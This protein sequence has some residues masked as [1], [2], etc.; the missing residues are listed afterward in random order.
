MNVRHS[1]HLEHAE[2]PV[3][4]TR[5]STVDSV[6]GDLA[7]GAPLSVKEACSPPSGPGGVYSQILGAAVA[8]AGSPF[9]LLKTFEYEQT[10]RVHAAPIS[11]VLRRRPATS[12]HLDNVPADLDLNCLDRAVE[13]LTRSESAMPTRVLVPRLAGAWSPPA[14]AHELAPHLVWL[15]PLYAG[16][17][18]LGVLG[19]SPSGRT[20]D[21]RWGH[22]L[23]V[24]VQSAA[25]VLQ[26]RDLEQRCARLENELR[27]REQRWD[28]A[29]E[30]SAGGT[31]DWDICRNELHLSPRWKAMFGTA[32]EDTPESL[33]AWRQLVHPEDLPRL[34]QAME[35]HLSGARIAFECEYR[36]RHHDASWRW[37]AGRGRVITW[38]DHG[39]PTRFV[40]T[41]TDITDH[42]ADEQA[43]LT[44]REAAVAAARGKSDLLTV[45]SH[46][47]RAPLNAVHGMATLLAGTPLDRQQH[48][49]VTAIRSDSSD[50]LSALDN[51][52]DLSTLQ[53]GELNV[54]PSPF[55][56]RALAT[57]VLYLVKAQAAAKD[58]SLR[59]NGPLHPVW[60]LGNARAVRQ[61]L[62]HL[63]DNA[64]KFTESG[65]ITVSFSHLNDEV[66]RLWFRIEDTGVGIPEDQLVTIFEPFVKVNHHQGSSRGTGLGL[67]IC[68]H[69]VQSLHGEIGV[70][71]REGRGSTFEVTMP[72]PL[73]AEPAL[74]SDGPADWS[75]VIEHKLRERAPCILVAEDNPVNQKVARAFLERL[76]ARVD[77][78]ENGLQAVQA[79]TRFP[80]DLVLMDCQMP[81]MDGFEATEQ[82]RRMEGNSGH[83]PVV[84]L[85]ANALERAR[86]RSVAVGMNAFLTKPLQGH[87][88]RLTLHDSLFGQTSSEKPKV[89]S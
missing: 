7:P 38:D 35:A 56:P 1:V 68:R 52:L 9:A 63:V 40:G 39:N 53:S 70:Q 42:K 43:L 84:A 15:F 76:G 44:A 51:V 60:T 16:G 62:L 21:H 74:P 80:Y 32:P 47:L 18:L 66:P 61:V 78:V 24:L 49:Y 31:F 33:S 46:E 82:I 83:T 4:D 30:A 64:V 5:A 79:L 3:N 57:D 86:E 34:T 72:A 20:E 59:F 65:T 12:W 36:L 13:Q 6:Y 22:V 26:A 75:A 25:C 88:L 10:W 11:K 67:T 55:D 45:I 85:T 41:Q 23:E 48:D 14:A 81:T 27:E 73:T 8:L 50:L 77:C 29:L 17:C 2:C 37:I 87:A 89:Q 28:F 69:L 58:L 54:E 71:S 19:V